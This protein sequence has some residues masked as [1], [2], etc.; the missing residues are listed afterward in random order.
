MVATVVM[1]VMV[2]AAELIAMV[3]LDHLVVRVVLM[4]LTG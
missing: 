2:V 1:V 4:G 3:A